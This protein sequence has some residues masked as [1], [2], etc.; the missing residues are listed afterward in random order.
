VH[1][2]S[3][4]TQARAAAKQTVASLTI[5]QRG[6]LSRNNRYVDEAGAIEAMTAS[7]SALV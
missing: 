2:N 7:T 5:A 1:Y 3:R 4:G 6:R